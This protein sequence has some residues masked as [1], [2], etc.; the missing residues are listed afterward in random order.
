MKKLTVLVLAVLFSGNLLLAQ[1]VEAGKKFLYYNRLTSATQTLEKAVAA[2]SKDANAIYWLGQA[3]LSTENAAGN[4][5]VA[6]AKELYQKALN[7][8]VNDPLI[9]VGMGHVELLEGKK[10]EAKQRFES[11]ITSSMKRKKENPDILNAIGRANADGGTEVGDPAYAIEKLKRAAELDPK[12]P[13]IYVNMGINY[14]KAGG[15]R[16]GGDAYEAFGNALRIDP[17]YAMANFRLGKIFQSQNNREKYEQ[18]FNAAIEADPAFAP[19]YLELY[20][21]YQN[22]DINKAREYL[23]KYIANSDKDCSTDYFYADYLFRS[24][25]YQEFLDRGKAMENGVCK[26]Y[27]RLKV[28]YAYNYNRLG[29]SLKAKENIESYLNNAAPGNIQPDDYMFASSVLKKVEGSEQNAI[30]YLEKALEFDTVRATR[31]VYMDTIAS[32]Y[33]K[34]GMNKERLD[35]LQKSYETNPIHLIWIFIILVMLH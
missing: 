21:Y 1:D 27:P 17:K 19:S 34:M 31:Y 11:A 13:D 8:G 16:S 24:G 30:K 10:D 35:W 25:K 22:R 29:D 26:D 14:L 15:E 12:N 28:L 23:D 33:R 32:L 2:N 18:Y 20:T 9:W 5:E 3:Y 4:K 6:K 7:E